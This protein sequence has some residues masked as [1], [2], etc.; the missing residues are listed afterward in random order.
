MSLLSVEGISK[1]KDN[2]F[3]LKDI[4]FGQ[5]RFQKLA[6]AGETGSG[7]STL[8]KIIAGLIQ[9]DSGKVMFQQQRV[10]G[11]EEKLLP[12]HPAIA[13]LSQHFEL[14]NNYR[15]E[16]ILEMA[17]KMSLKEAE[18]IFEV[19]QVNHLLKRRTDQLS[20]GE[21]Q[22]IA[23]ARLLIT[24]PQLLLLDEP[25]SNLDMLHKQTMKAV[26]NDIGERLKITSILISH[27]PLD[28]LSWAEK[29]LVMKGGQ[30]IQQGEPHEIYTKP[31]DEYV[32]G[33]F[34]KYNLLNTTH[35]ELLYEQLG[36]IDHDKNIF[37]RPEDFKI[38][39][40]E[41]RAI[42]GVINSVD[43]F[44]SYYEI[45]VSL[46]RNIITVKS[47]HN[48]FAKGDTIHLFF[49]EEGLWYV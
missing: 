21:K 22:R 41:N 19:C 28:T 46:G 24:K 5:E 40:K 29:I 25:F 9:P 16:E 44:G 15:V 27:D 30:V 33:L 35:F 31:K 14:R 43:Y 7:K 49:D 39:D 48:K 42:K 26:V 32:G 10:E 36:A 6:I 17:N 37:I 23:L 2:D 20:G 18:T 4:S 11:P 12:G 45:Q 8:L 38:V 3:S 34:G 1:K 47:T 13:Y